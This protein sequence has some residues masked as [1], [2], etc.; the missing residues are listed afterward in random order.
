[1]QRSRTASPVA[2]RVGAI[3]LAIVVNL[4][5]LFASR[6]IAGAWPRAKAGSDVQEIMAVAVV[7][8]TLVAGILAWLVAMLVQR[9]APKPARTWL[10]VGTIAWL[11]SLL[12]LPGA[13]NTS[14]TITL[15]LL[16][17]VTAAILIAAIW[18]TMPAGRT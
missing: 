2:I 10:I 13:Q 15:G 8:A 9:V 17:T 1:M 11:L 6:G 12:A 4:V 5:I 18:R 16:H 14:S 3:V 7:A